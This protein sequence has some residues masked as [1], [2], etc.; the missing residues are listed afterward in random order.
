MGITLETGF[1]RPYNYKPELDVSSEI[2]LY[3][4]EIH[5]I[6]KLGWKPVTMMNG[7]ING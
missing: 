2:D 4:E 3:F 6:F 1:I 7:K 5:G